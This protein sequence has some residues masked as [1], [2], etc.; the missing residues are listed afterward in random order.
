MLTDTACIFYV[1][2]LFVCLLLL[3]FIL[4]MYDPLQIKNLPKGATVIDYA[5]MIHT[6][7]GNSMVAAKASPFCNCLM[8]IF[9]D[10]RV[11]RVKSNNHII[12]IIIIRSMAILFL[13][14]MCLQMQKLWR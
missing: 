6:D 2:L 7:I 5:Y 14:C 10:I 3:H 13:P 4:Y 1:S 8:S 9:V 12:I 11:S